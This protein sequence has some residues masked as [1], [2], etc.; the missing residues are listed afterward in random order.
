MVLLFSD[1]L[2]ITGIAVLVAGFAIH[3]ALSVYHLPFSARDM[4]GLG[5]IQF[6]SSRI[7]SIATL[8]SI[9]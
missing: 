3:P 1:Q 5:C 2:N 9:T 7:D 8:P 6:A 4:A